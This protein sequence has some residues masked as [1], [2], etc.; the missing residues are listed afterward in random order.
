MT[1]LGG[2][3]P[4]RPQGLVERLAAAGCVAAEEEAGELLAAAAGDPGLLARLVDRRLGG[5][6]LAWVTGE[7]TF[8][9]RRIGVDRGVYVPRWQT[10]ALALRAVALLPDRGTAVD[11]CTGSGAI[12]AV[13]ADARPGALVV[14]SDIDPRACACA[15][16]NNVDVYQG[17]LADPLPPHVRGRADVVVAVAPYVPTGAIQYLPRD[18]RGHEPVLALDGGPEG[19]DLLEEVV[20]AAAGLLRPAAAL[21]LELG[22]GQ[23]VLLRPALR[24]AGFGVPT[25]HLDEDGDLR[26]IEVVLG[27]GR[28]ASSPRLPA[29]EVP[30]RADGG[31]GVH[32]Q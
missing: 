8:L 30:W 10:Q 24:R 7:V 29:P 20:D 23:D 11:L 25:R 6:P 2:D 22:A 21:L 27:A 3:A 32:H 14:A 9:G 5:E 4:P 18:A 26:A 16:G 15:A 28:A 31:P 1:G 17:H 19:I 12:A 13:L